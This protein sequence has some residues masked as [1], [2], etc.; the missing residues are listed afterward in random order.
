M[1]VTSIFSRRSLVSFAIILSLVSSWQACKPRAETRS[2]LQQRD[3]QGRGSFPIWSYDAG[4]TP[5]TD[6]GNDL[7]NLHAALPYFPGL[8]TAIF[9][10]QMF[11]PA[12]GPVVWRM[13]QEPNSIKIL[14]IGQ[15]ATHIAEAAGRTATAGFGGRAQD[16]AKYFGVGSSAAFINTY[17]Y[18]IRWQYSFFD[19]PII[20][21]SG[22]SEKLSYGSFTSNPVWLLS[23][24][25]DSPIVRW[26]NQMISWIIKN[27]RQSLKMIVLFGG[28]AR[29]TMGSFVVANGGNVG[30]RY[31]DA[32]IANL[33]I[34]EFKAVYSGGNTQ[35][36]SPFTREGQDLYREFAGT[37]PTYDDEAKMN[38]LRSKFQREFNSAPAR[39]SQKM[40]FSGGGIGG[41]GILHPAQLG[42]YDVNRKM[43]ING[44][45]TIS[46]KGLKLSDGSV[47]ENDLL[48]SQLP[49]PTALSN[50]SDGD[51][52]SAV[53]SGIKPLEPFTRAGWKIEPDSGFTSAF[54]E[55]RDYKYAR[56]SMGTEYYDFGA[57]SS[58]MVNVSSASR[59]S[60]NVIVFGT[61][62]KV[63]F[64]EEAIKAMTFATPSSYPPANEVWLTKP[65]STDGSRNPGPKNRRY[66]FDP[67]PPEEFAKIMKTILPTD[68]GF[69]KKRSDNGDYGHYR[70][71][72]KAP[73]VLIVADPDGYDDLVTARA[74]TGTR[75][76]YLQSLMDGMGVSDKYLV[77]KTAPYGQDP[78]WQ[79][80]FNAT[81]PYREALFKKIIAS[82]KPELIITDGRFAKGE[83]ER[84]LGSE[85][86][87]IVNIE[88][89]G[90]ANSSGIAQAL[91]QI[92]KVR[93][94]TQASFSGK[95]TDIPR[96]HLTY[97]ARA[98]EGTSGDRVLAS[99][100]PKY[101]GVAY[102][103]VAPKWVSQQKYS[104]PAIEINGCEKLFKKSLQA[105]IRLGGE[106][107]SR[108]A[109][110]LRSGSTPA[111]P[112][113]ASKSSS[114]DAPEME[115]PASDEEE[116][117]SR[118][119]RL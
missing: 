85:G 45:T 71:T 107:V 23:Q 114:S 99:S 36:A 18:T 119:E 112:C 77:I 91:P 81:K 58:R 24:D 60:T 25:V 59:L 118:V 20:S 66:T 54:A 52:S 42:G 34:P 41:S 64:D 65:N 17:P 82:H 8:S 44:K 5:K 98:W 69:I 47:I 68:S 111:S 116:N 13:L 103:F 84:I 79:E 29:D 6:L 11:R 10:D 14:F 63:R 93:G 28:A 46:L 4:P 32:D 102:A 70:G 87:A 57:P 97:Y 33:K 106:S 75:G 90:L 55:G 89:S 31:S 101:A 86:V 1:K 92:K 30:S 49:H 48:V 109:D 9:G 72:F 80:T 76:Q 100:D 95:M 113:Q 51:A 50:M 26:R 88:R 78:D 96:S 21:G 62:D 43:S 19:T 38:D 74:L 35:A 22:G 61:R 16:L 105:K 12:F 94:F 110:R 83:V 37:N 53:K 3:F 56:A 67:G 15:D 73:R 40:V 104:M 117:E 115:T 39:W 108:M 2:E 7:I 27:N